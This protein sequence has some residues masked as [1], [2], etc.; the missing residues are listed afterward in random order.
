[1]RKTPAMQKLTVADGVEIAYIIHGSTDCPPFLAIT[2]LVE[3]AAMWP[4]GFVDS[5]VGA[6]Y[7][8]VAFD[9]RDIGESTRV[10][11]APPDMK[12]ARAQLAAG[13]RPDMPYSLHDLAADAVGLIDGLGLESVHLFGYSMGGYIAQSLAARHPERTRSLIAA[14]TSSR[15]PALPP[16]PDRVRRATIGLTEHTDAETVIQ[17]MID[18][19]AQTSGSRY[20]T[21]LAERRAFA[22]AAMAAGFDP[23]SAA[24]QQLAIFGTPPFGDELGRIKAPTTIVQG[25][26]DCFFSI[27]HG[28]DLANR[29][30][31]ARLKTINGAGHSLS[32]SLVPE[33][34]RLVLE[35]LQRAQPPDQT[36]LAE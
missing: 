8:F 10:R 16:V 15:S 4:A 25:S 24:R 26:D 22:D 19:G 28:E 7:C 18:F 11:E 36:A 9:N 31:G 5:V 34:S 14:M 13:I 33:I 12:E 21:T 17:R 29:V 3:G 32:E 30:P 35:H 6:G 2:G 1:M 23:D 20:S 27:E